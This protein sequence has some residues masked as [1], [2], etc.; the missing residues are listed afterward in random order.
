M[1]K[2]LFKWNLKNKE[3]DRSEVKIKITVPSVRLLLLRS[4]L[5]SDKKLRRRFK[6]WSYSRDK[7]SVVKLFKYGK[8]NI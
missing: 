8:N 3:L 6:E 7:D 1:Y 4:K 2:N 5:K